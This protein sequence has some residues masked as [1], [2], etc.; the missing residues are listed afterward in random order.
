MC[1]I[2][3]SVLHRKDGSSIPEWFKFPLSKDQARFIQLSAFPTMNMSMI[4]LDAEG[5]LGS[6]AIDIP[7]VRDTT[8]LAIQ[9][10]SLM[11]FPVQKASLDKQGK[12]QSMIF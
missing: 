7:I 11:H 4:L 12:A 10:L 5:E 3:D 9:R 8:N 6:N 1:T 2:G